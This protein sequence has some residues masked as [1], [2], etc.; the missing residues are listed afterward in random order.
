MLRSLDVETLCRGKW[1][2][3]TFLH[4]VWLFTDMQ[5]PA[6]SYNM[7]THPVF[8]SADTPIGQSVGF[9]NLPGLIV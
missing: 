4:L 8:Y 3:Y 5:R 7:E 6:C 2:D 1:I 9:V